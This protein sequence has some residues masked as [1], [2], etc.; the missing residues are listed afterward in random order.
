MLDPELRPRIL[1][2]FDAKNQSWDAK[3]VIEINGLKGLIG[4]IFPLDA[5]RA[6]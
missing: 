1:T 6:L 2:F 3:N 5:R 4:V